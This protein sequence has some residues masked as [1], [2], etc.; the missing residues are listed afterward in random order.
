MQTLDVGIL[1]VEGNWHWKGDV[2]ERTGF[3]RARYRSLILGVQWLEG[4]LVI[5]TTGLE[6]TR[7]TLQQLEAWFENP[8]QRNLR[9]RPKPRDHNPDVFTCQSVPGWNVRSAEALLDYFGRLPVAPTV[10]EAELCAVPGIG[11]GRAR[12]FLKAF[13]GQ[14]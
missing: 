4:I 14:A 3:T 13:G 12:A 5:E 2:S 7:A 6:D 1:I 9:G 8:E 10:T 11:K